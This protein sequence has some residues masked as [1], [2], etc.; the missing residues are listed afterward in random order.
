[1]SHQSGAQVA[2][3][4]DLSSDAARFCGEVEAAFN[5][6]LRVLRVEGRAS[7]DER[8]D[9]RYVDIVATEASREQA[10]GRAQDEFLETDRAMHPVPVLDP[11]QGRRVSIEELTSFL[12]AGLED[13]RK[14]DRAVD[15]RHII[16]QLT[17][18][19]RRRARFAESGNGA[20]YLNEICD[21]LNT[22]RD[23]RLADNRNPYLFAQPADNFG[24]LAVRTGA[25]EPVLARS[26]AVASHFDAAPK[27]PSSGIKLDLAKSDG[28]IDFPERGGS[29]NFRSRRTVLTF[30]LP[31]FGLSY[32]FQL[33][34]SRVT[35]RS[36]AAE[37]SARIGMSAAAC[38]F[39]VSGV[40]LY[41]LPG[42]PSLPTIQPRL[43]A[44]AEPAKAT[45]PKQDAHTTQP[46]ISM[47]RMPL[48]EEKAP[49]VEP[50]PVAITAPEHVVTRSTTNLRTRPDQ[51]AQVV[52]VVPGRLI[53]T[54]F[55]HS[56]DWVQVGGAE[57]WGWVP[58]GL[59]LPFAPKRD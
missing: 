36:A 30:G 44:L 15:A 29:I 12:I 50:T 13:A 51:S 46:L 28:S 11:G 22:A 14:H 25:L 6:V 18:G 37:G 31:R 5:G 48:F 41:A 59:I 26:N 56:D 43:A 2:L 1:M 3:D 32:Q 16:A 52:R 47:M 24:S 40:L 9:G 17:E 45:P 42:L 19:L 53:L 35:S 55:A 54:V 39:L 57:A 34:S 49:V 4:A 20:E 7:D 58:S 23:F 27:E 8:Q 10:Q 38:A 21:F 33:N